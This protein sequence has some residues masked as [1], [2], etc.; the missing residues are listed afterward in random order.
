MCFNS[1]NAGLNYALSV[2]GPITA[3][4]S[5]TLFGVRRQFLINFADQTRVRTTHCC[6]YLKL[7]FPPPDSE[8]RIS[9]QRS[10]T[11]YKTNQCVL[12]CILVY[13]YSIITVIKAVNLLRLLECPNFPRGYFLFEFYCIFPFNYFSIIRISCNANAISLIDYSIVLV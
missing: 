10:M 11:S 12:L 6:N 7:L 3:S 8:K 4:E 9:A 1:L 5:R 13:V 2:C